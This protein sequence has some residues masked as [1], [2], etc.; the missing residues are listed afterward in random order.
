MEIPLLLR[1]PLCFHDFL[2]SCLVLG[3]VFQCF[4]YACYEQGQEPYGNVR[5][6]S[7]A[8]FDIHGHFVKFP[9]DCSSESSLNCAF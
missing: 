3:S 7:V 8:R 1:M 2:I 9:K 5:G 4:L 6:Y